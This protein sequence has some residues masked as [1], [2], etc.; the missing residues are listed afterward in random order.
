[1]AIIEL[2]KHV[3]YGEP[4]TRQY[5]QGRLFA[6]D[7]R[8]LNY[9]MALSSPLE[10]TVTSRHWKIGPILN[11]G[12]TQ[13]C[14]AYSGEQFLTTYPVSNKPY[15]DPVELYKLCQLNDEWRD[16]PHEG[17]SVRALFKILKA[18]GYI[19]NYSWAF[20]AGTVRRFVLMNGPV[21]LGTNWYSGMYD[22]DRRGF[23]RP[24]GA[25]SGGHAYLVRGAEDNIT[26]PDGSR[27][28]FRIVNAWGTSWGQD[29]KAWLSYKDA[30]GLIKNYGEAVTAIEVLNS[31]PKPLS[32]VINEQ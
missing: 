29:G 22:I 5:G 2:D 23:I 30:D 13:H 28:A 15:T 18:A 21:V 11:Q 31:T 26:C 12:L 4:S 7:F 1:M 3:V 9:P 27:G 25:P 14:V 16:V 6:A 32:G 20:D 19:D 8:D 10:P 17:T 24:V